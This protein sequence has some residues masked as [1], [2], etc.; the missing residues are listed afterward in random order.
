MSTSSANSA[1]SPAVSG[2][3]YD[4][5]ALT[6]ALPGSSS[7]TA[8]P[9]AAADRK[10]AHADHYKPPSPKARAVGWPPVRAYRRNAL[11][12]EAKL[13]KVAV[14]GAPYL[15][16]VDLAAHDGYAALL[17]A[18][19]GMFASC[20]GADGAGRLVDTATGAEYV[21][22]YEDKDGDWMLVGDVPFKM[23]VDSCKRIRLMK[24]SE[25]VN[26]SPRTA[27]Q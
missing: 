11:R 2:L 25:A 14:D 4:D 3:D 10:R 24:S 21:P 22:T 8:D 26:L 23:F 19:H 20:L 6:L 9:T 27:S 1:A 13:V 5:T 17:L 16:K 15:R 18:L 12:D 7:S